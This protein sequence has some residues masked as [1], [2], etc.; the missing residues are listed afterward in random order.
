LAPETAQR[1]R[2]LRGAAHSLVR[3]AQADDEPEG[4]P[5]DFSAARIWLQMKEISQPVGLAPF[6]VHSKG[7]SP[8]DF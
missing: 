4:L 3:A 7:Q 2:S 6:N 5:R 1:W 8:M